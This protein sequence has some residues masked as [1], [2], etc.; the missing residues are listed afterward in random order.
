MLA[1]IC[2]VLESIH[3]LSLISILFLTIYTTLYLVSYHVDNTQKTILPLRY[4]LFIIFIS[5]IIFILTPTGLQ[6]TLLDKYRL[7]NEQ[8]RLE[9]QE[10]KLKQLDRWNIDEKR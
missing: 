8:L 9:I 1:Y 10:I 6:F 7:E 5:C 4:I 2:G 3:F